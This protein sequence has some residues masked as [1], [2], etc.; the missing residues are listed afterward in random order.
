ML[1]CTAHTVLLLPSLS[2][3]H[4]ERTREYYR[5]ALTPEVVLGIARNDMVL[6]DTSI[7]PVLLRLQI[8]LQAVLRVTLEVG[9]VE[10]VFGQLVHLRQ[11]L[12]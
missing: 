5:T 8:R 7:Q 3:E 6:R 2:R 12:P 11:Q 4:K 9:H 1:A 10:L